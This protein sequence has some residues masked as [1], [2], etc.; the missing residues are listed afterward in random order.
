MELYDIKADAIEEFQIDDVDVLI[1]IHDF[2]AENKETIANELKRRYLQG[3]KLSKMVYKVIFENFNY[4][5]DSVEIIELLK[6]MMLQEKNNELPKFDAFLSNAKILEVMYEKAMNQF[7]E[8]EIC[9]YLDENKEVP[10]DYCKF[11]YDYCLEMNANEPDNKECVEET[12]DNWKK[13]IADFYTSSLLNMIE[14][15]G[16]TVEDYLSL[17]ERA[18]NFNPDNLEALKMKIWCL[19]QNNK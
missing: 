11:F 14:H 18:L 3:E 7:V 8:I 2:M 15:G 12:V 1:G 4:K 5:K 9:D 13:K 16:Y 19:E 6:K 10:Y 17:C